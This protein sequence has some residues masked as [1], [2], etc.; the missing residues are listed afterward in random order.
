MHA[1]SSVKRTH[2]DLCVIILSAVA[3][4]PCLNGNPQNAK[5]NNRLGRTKFQFFWFLS[6]SGKKPLSLKFFIQ[7][8][9]ILVQF[10]FL[11]VFRVL[12][13]KNSLLLVCN[14]AVTFL[15]FS[16]LLF[17]VSVFMTCR[18]LGNKYHMTS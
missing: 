10:S 4:V 5:Y 12:L 3:V 9:K 16:W 6:V 8:S 1:L 13:K 18:V 11:F 14:A 17:S 7:P 15:K 2:K